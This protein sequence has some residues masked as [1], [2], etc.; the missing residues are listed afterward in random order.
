MD[1]ILIFLIDGSSPN[2]FYS[3]RKKLKK[4]PWNELTKADFMACPKLYCPMIFLPFL[5][6][7]DTF[8]FAIYIFLLFLLAFYFILL[9]KIIIK[10]NEF[11]M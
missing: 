11:I 7:F 5:T 10:L 4:S 1:E 9:K 2:Y 3:N 8:F 6:L